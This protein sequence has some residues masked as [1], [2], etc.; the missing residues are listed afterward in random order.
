MAK[1]L[2]IDDY[3]HYAETAALILERREGHEVPKSEHAV[4]ARG[5]GLVPER[6]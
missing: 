2:G 3:R 1:I 4:A 6:P 5:Q